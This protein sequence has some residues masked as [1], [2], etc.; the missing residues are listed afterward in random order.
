MTAQV[1]T[2]EK[3]ARY[4]LPRPFLKW[5]G[6]KTQLL[7]NLLE[8]IPKYT[9]RY[10]EP[11]VGGGALFFE[12]APK[13]AIISDLNQEL[14]DCYA[15]IRDEPAAVIRALKKHKYEKEHYY[16]IRSQSP[17]RMST[18]RRAARMIYLNRAGFNG[19][20]RVNSKGE[21]N[22]PFGRHANPM[23][24]DEENLTACSAALHG[25]DIR[26]EP[27]ESVLSNAESG[28]FVYFDPPYIPISDTAFFTAYEKSGFGME[29]Q[30]RLADVFD[31]LAARGV[32][33]LLSNADV[34]WIRDRFKGH[35]VH[36]VL[37][38]RSVNSKGHKRGPVGE[39]IVASFGPQPARRAIASS[40][41][42]RTR[43]GARSSPKRIVKRLMKE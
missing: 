5:V 36:S 21:F 28:D 24:C 7:P 22:V 6:G 4:R 26:C 12:H 38:N 17:F 40:R 14:I 25:V 1:K 29:N 33:A 18:A 2:K 42:S 8:M 15:A 20:Y 3:L 11:F 32:F 31:T 35:R 39:V 43:L 13:D 41:K 19:L 34:P 16:I 9:G 27:F 10:H 37:A 23:I 30:A